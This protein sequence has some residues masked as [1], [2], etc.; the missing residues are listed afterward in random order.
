VQ[1]GGQPGP[2]RSR[3]LGPFAVQLSLQ[4]QDL[5]PEREDLGVLVV[6]AHRQ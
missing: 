6:V 4:D 1:Q 2:V 3:E 5:V